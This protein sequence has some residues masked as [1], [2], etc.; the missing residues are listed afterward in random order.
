MRSVARRFTFSQTTVERYPSSSLPFTRQE[1]AGNSKWNC[2][3]NMSASLRHAECV[4]QYCW[5]DSFANNEACEPIRSCQKAK[6]WNVVFLLKSNGALTRKR[7]KTVVH[8][9]SVVSNHL[10]MSLFICLWP[11]DSCITFTLHRNDELK[12]FIYAWVTLIELHSFTYS[13]DKKRT[14]IK[15]WV[16]IWWFLFLRSRFE[17]LS[18]EF[19]QYHRESALFLC[20]YVKLEQTRTQ[21]I[22]SCLSIH[23][24]LIPLSVSGLDLQ[25][26]LPVTNPAVFQMKIFHHNL[27]FRA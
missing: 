17:A 7:P 15:R 1:E 2:Q 3:S 20:V 9:L 11:T 21:A 16:F 25:T 5:I 22:T 6:Q 10:L 26:A 14:K 23:P 27:V 18:I 8:I 13:V 4:H 24:L 12:A 19:T